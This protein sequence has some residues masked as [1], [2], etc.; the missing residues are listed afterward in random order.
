MPVFYLVSVHRVQGAVVRGRK[1]FKDMDVW[2][3]AAR[4]AMPVGLI[5]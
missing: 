1:K 3:R 2:K 4:S 5:R